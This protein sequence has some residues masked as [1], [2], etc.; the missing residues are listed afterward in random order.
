MSQRLMT[1]LF[2]FGLLGLAVA[3]VVLYA[4]FS[5]VPLGEKHRPIDELGGPIHTTNKARPIF[6]F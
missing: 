3:I 2:V 4:T 5:T 6:S 1:R